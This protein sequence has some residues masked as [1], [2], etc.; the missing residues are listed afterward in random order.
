MRNVIL[1]ALLS[2]VLYG[3]A[4][5]LGSFVAANRHNLAEVQYGMTPEQVHAVMGQQT[6]RKRYGNPFR[7]A[8]HRDENDEPV[9][10]FYYWTDGSA[11]DGIQ[12]N[13]LTPVVFRSGHVIGWGREFF[14]E[15]IEQTLPAV[16]VKPDESARNRDQEERV[17]AVDLAA[18]S[19]AG[20]ATEGSWVIAV[21]SVADPFAGIPMYPRSSCLGAVVMGVC[22]GEI[23]HIGPV[24]RRCYGEILNGKCTG[25]AY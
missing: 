13:E 16:S 7:T 15:P 24:P 6:V 22:K 10:V 5:G 20:V 1:S 11:L 3:C 2:C 23:L 4:V 19:E 17:Q 12:D 25:K 8:M 21:E 18:G 9:D 14:A